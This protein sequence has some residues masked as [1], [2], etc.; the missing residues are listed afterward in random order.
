MKE[1][2][3]N[4]TILTVGLSVV[5]WYRQMNKHLQGLKGSISAWARYHEEK[6]PKTI[7]KTYAFVILGLMAPFMY[8]G[9]NTMLGV[10]PPLFMGAIAGFTGY[11][12]KFKNKKLENALHVIFTFIG[13]GGY[14]YILI[15]ISWYNAIFAGLW[16][17]YVLYAWG[18]KIYHHTRKIEYY[19]IYMGY[20][21]LYIIFVIIPIFRL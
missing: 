1:I 5:I 13:M 15:T 10:F 19:G 16:L 21:L 9:R 8:F 20:G 6:K 4:F 18:T 2:L 7:W 14:C 11:N 3:I 12:P 17:L